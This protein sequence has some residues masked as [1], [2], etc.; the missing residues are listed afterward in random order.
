MKTQTRIKVAGIITAL[1]VGGVTAF[2]VASRDSTKA[3]DVA[4]V[5]AATQAKP[6]VVHRRKVKTVH[7]K[8]KDVAG[9]TPA[10]ASSGS[11]A[12][13][14]VVAPAAQ[15]AV[16]TAPA[17]PAPQST[18]DDGSGYADDDDSAEHEEE[19]EGGDD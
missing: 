17:P 6:Q 13:P 15:P 4:V 8:A 19:E 7:P 14:A 1:F 11:S 5:E 16:V 2:G 9:A 3:D 10:A 12:S 18:G